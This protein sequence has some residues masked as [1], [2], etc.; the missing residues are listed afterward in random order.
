[1]NELSLDCRQ[2]FAFHEHRDGLILLRRNQ[3]TE[4]GFLRQLGRWVGRHLK[5]F[6]VCYWRRRKEENITIIIFSDTLRKSCILHKRANS[7]CI[8]LLW[9][10]G[11][12]RKLFLILVNLVF[13]NWLPL[14]PE[15]FGSIELFIICE[16]VGGGSIADFTIG[17][18]SQKLFGIIMGPELA[19]WWTGEV[20][21]DDVVRRLLLLLLRCCG[22]PKLSIWFFI[23]PDGC[24]IGVF[25]DAGDDGRK[26]P[27]RTWTRWIN[28]VFIEVDIS[29]CCSM[30]TIL[31]GSLTDSLRGINGNSLRRTLLIWRWS[32]SSWRWRGRSPW[33]TIAFTNTGKLIENQYTRPLIIINCHEYICVLCAHE[34]RRKTHLKGERRVAMGE[35]S[36]IC[37]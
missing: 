18:L 28:K 10:R 21:H 19:R 33:T 34:W 29:D 5:N 36:L 23:R 24:R 12:P 31:I 27:V 3:V 15:P 32:W 6:F 2:W 11:L 8:F 37:P 35:P 20:V 7:L 17:S 16:P 30:T 13:H 1:M 9:K 22:V 25:V 14:V 4:P 26:T